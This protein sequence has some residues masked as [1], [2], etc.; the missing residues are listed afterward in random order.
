MTTIPKTPT[1]SLFSRVTAV[2]VITRLILGAGVQIFFPFLPIIAA[3]LNIS[4]ITL[5][6]FLGLRGVS[7]LVAPIFG[8]TADKR[9][10][11]RIIQVALLLAATGN[12]LIYFSQSLPVF[13]VGLF[14]LGIGTSGVTPTLV[15]YMSHLLP[16]ERRSRG[17]GMLEYTWALV[18]IMVLPLF[19]WLIDGTSWRLPFLLM[20]GLEIIAIFWFMNLPPVSTLPERPTVRPA[21]SVVL[22]DF[23][24]F[25]ANWRSAWAVLLGD[26]FTKFSGNILSISFGIWLLKEYGLTASRLGQ[27]AFLLGFA[28]ICGSGLVSLVGDRLGKRRSVLVATA[29]GVLFFSTLPLWNQSLTTAVIGLFLARWTFEFSIVSHIVLASEQ[30]PAQRGKMLTMRIGL[31][32]IAVTLGS[33]WGPALYAAFGVA[34]IGVPGAISMALAWLVARFLTVERG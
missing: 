6:R 7:A 2:I 8:T 21:L 28:D 33:I 15:A 23:F 10:Y 9:G 29:F 5:G 26:S 22:R 14:I 31:G 32:F 19:G 16:F 3:G 18:G 12:L 24:D 4:E 34:G 27:V 25:G 17:L 13:V 30:S 1:I 20:G 11:R